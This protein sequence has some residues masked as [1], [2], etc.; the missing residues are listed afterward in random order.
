[1]EL[2]TERDERMAE[3]SAK[4]MPESQKA[5]RK[6]LDGKVKVTFPGGHAI[7]HVFQKGAPHPKG[8][9]A[10]IID[11]RVEVGTGFGREFRQE[12]MDD[13]INFA[14]GQSTKFSVSEYH[15]EK[16]EETSNAETSSGGSE[17]VDP[18]S[19]QSNQSES[20]PQ[21]DMVAGGDTPVQN[22]EPAKPSD[23]PAPAAV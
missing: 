2:K 12:V 13:A 3:E 22:Q 8:L 5:M 9:D 14:R 6:D 11:N 4:A 18:Q 10:V 1:M 17:S 21:G 7:V 23:S 19:G 20:A 16:K 15:E